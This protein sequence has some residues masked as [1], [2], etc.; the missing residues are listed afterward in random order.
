[1]FTGAFAKT[2]HTFWNRQSDI[3][4]DMQAVSDQWFERRHAG[5]KAALAACESMCNAKTPVECFLAY[6]LWAMGAM[7]RLMADGLTLHQ[8]FRKIADEIGPPMVPGLPGS[9]AEPASPG[10]KRRMDEAA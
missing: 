3:L 9:T 2:A 5:T 7:Q 6:Q 10:A 4:D 1:M 8:G